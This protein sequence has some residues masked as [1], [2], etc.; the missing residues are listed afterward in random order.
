MKMFKKI[1]PSLSKN[2]FLGGFLS[3]NF[4]SHIG[5]VNGGLSILDEDEMFNGLIFKRLSLNG[6]VLILFCG[7]I[8]LWFILSYHS[9]FHN[10]RAMGDEKMSLKGGD[11]R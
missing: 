7:K 1:A 8:I 9:R 2:D 11:M 6:G 5:H 4:L 3:H 10:R